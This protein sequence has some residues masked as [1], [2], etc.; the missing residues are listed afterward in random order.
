MKKMKNDLFKIFSSKEMTDMSFHQIQGGA[1]GNKTKAK[2]ST[3]GAKSKDK[4][5]ECCGTDTDIWPCPEEC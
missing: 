1:I 4:K 3:T 5:D 2:S